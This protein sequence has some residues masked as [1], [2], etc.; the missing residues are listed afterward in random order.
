MSKTFTYHHTVL[1][2]YSAAQVYAV[3]DDVA[4]YA[5]F[6]PNCASSG[7]LSRTSIGNGTEHIQGYMDLA[8]LGLRHRLDSDN[9]H[10]SP[11]QIDMQLLKGPFKQL[12]GRWQFMALGDAGCKVSLSMQ[13]QYNN[14][15]LAMT[16]GQRFEGIA[17]QLLDAFILETVRRSS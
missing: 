10:I 11:S 12:T 4:S 2:P 8:F 17:K 14:A 6:L 16:L 5:A 3:V 13:W 15:L 7:I 1:V 9:R